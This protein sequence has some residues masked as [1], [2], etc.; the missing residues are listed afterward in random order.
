MWCPPGASS[1]L[2]TVSRLCTGK[3]IETQNKH[4]PHDLDSRQVIIV[5]TQ[6]EGS[7]GFS[8]AHRLTHRVAL[9]PGLHDWGPQGAEHIPRL[10]T[11]LDG[12]HAPRPL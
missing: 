12:L 9:Q 1:R 7:G 4:Q 5:L 3:I 10:D 2:W 8:I 6:L 11:R